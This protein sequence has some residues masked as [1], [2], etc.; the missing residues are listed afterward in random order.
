ME[1]QIAQYVL[2]LKDDTDFCEKFDE[3][4]EK[5]GVPEILRFPLYSA[6]LN[7]K[8]FMV[9]TAHKVLKDN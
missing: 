4:C 3:K 9:E 6:I 8:F 2:E 5:L 7:D 1:K